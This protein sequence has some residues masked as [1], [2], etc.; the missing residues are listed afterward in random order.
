MKAIGTS[1]MVCGLLC[2]WY[3]GVVL[4][5]D[6]SPLTA[7]TA[8]S[9]GILL[10]LGVL[11]LVLRHAWANLTRPAPPQAPVTWAVSRN[12]KFRITVAD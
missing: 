7:L 10:L 12:G 5:A 1:S 6:G 11:L 8:K 2:L 3:A 9:G 4:H